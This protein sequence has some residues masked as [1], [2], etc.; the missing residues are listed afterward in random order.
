MTEQPYRWEYL[1]VLEFIVVLMKR[2][3]EWSRRNKS[4]M[5]LF[6]YRQ[7]PFYELPRTNSVQINKLCED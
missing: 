5:V 2:K 3:K 4:R 6:F 7:L 1:K